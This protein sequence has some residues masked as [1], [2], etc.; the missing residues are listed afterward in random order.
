MILASTVSTIE[1]II[2][3][4]ILTGVILYILLRLFAS[5]WDARKKKD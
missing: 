1:A 2:P 4:V 3:F 5:F